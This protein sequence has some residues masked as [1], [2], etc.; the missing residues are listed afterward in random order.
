VFLSRLWKDLFTHQGVQLLQSTAYHPQTD[1]QTEVV[2]KCL[3]QYLQCMTSKTPD[4]W[5]QW[6]PLAEWWYNTSYHSSIKSTPFE[7]L[8]GQN[9]PVHIHYLPKDSNMEVVDR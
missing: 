6:L 7:V 3:E 1:G 9:P 2:N 4:Q 8:Y 5:Y